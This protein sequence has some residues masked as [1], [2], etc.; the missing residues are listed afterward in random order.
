MV[1]M[2]TG[3]EGS[4]ASGRHILA[5]RMAAEPKRRATPSARKP[6]LVAALRRTFQ[7]ASYTYPIVRETL[8]ADETLTTPAHQVPLVGRRLGDG[9]LA[10]L[11]RLFLIAAPVTLEQATRTL[12]PLT[13]QDAVSMGI[14][15]LGRSRV[16]GAV[17]ILPTDDGLFASDLDTADP[18]DL[19][20]DFVMGVT[21]S[22]RLLARLTIRRPIEL[23]LDV[24][25]GCGYQAVLAAK[26]ADRVIATD[27][28][29]RALEFT[30]FNALLNG[31]TNVECRRGDRFSPVD[32][33]TF[34]LIVSNPPFVISPDRTFV[35]RD[36]GLSGDSVSHEL[37]QATPRHLRADGLASILVSWIHAAANDDWSAPLR[38]WVADS[39]CDGWFL[40]KGS[41]DP[42]AYAVMWNQRL[43]LANQMQRYIDSVDRWTRYFERLGIS[44]MG[45]GAV[46]LRKRAGGVTRVREDE[47]PEDG[48]GERAAT[49]LERLLELEDALATMDDSTLLGHVLALAP[50]HRLEQVL[51]W[52][53]GGFR[54][55]EATLVLE[56]GL[57]PKAEVDAPLAALLAQVDGK[58]TIA[59]VLDRTAQAVATEDRS[60]AFRAQGFAAVRE[61]IAHGFL[62]L[63]AG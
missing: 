4:Q 33:L 13:L 27:V 50:E 48:V 42:L 19:P 61:L 12:A 16:H 56:R 9:P 26:H 57:R 14:V 43:A 58:R 24:G 37:V 10:T 32:D 35:Y 17:R 11:I 62:V 29:P 40:R 51:R 46:L 23:A 34:D 8:N 5:Q 6:D 1:G 44:A 25:T 53:D 60:D 39:G 18:A 2:P 47:L 49:E 7:A 28:N 15:S 52:R 21:D 30:A 31:A 41:Y 45:Y 55:V 22:T 59:E 3:R 36:S 54:T 38:A 63:H 20:A